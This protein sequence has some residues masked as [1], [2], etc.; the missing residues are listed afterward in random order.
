M[1]ILKSGTERLFEEQI[2]RIIIR[3]AYEISFIS[4]KGIPNRLP[5]YLVSRNK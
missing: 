3:L 1:Y 2:N 4:S 5:F